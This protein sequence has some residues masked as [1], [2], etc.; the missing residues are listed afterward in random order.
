MCA[1][2]QYLKVTIYL[3]PWSEKYISSWSEGAPESKPPTEGLFLC[4]ATGQWRPNVHLPPPKQGRLIPFRKQLMLHLIGKMHDAHKGCLQFTPVGVSWVH[5]P[6]NIHHSICALSTTQ[7]APSTINLKW[8]RY[9]VGTS[10]FLIS[11]FPDLLTVR[12]PNILKYPHFLIC[13]HPAGVG[14]WEKAR[15]D[16]NLVGRLHQRRCPGGRY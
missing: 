3:F 12:Y 11:P 16:F 4:P 9:K 14:V 5:I 6:W 10:D 15:P 2:G 1:C 7:R 8:G 13:W